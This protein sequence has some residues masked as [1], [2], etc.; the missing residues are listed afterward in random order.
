MSGPKTVV[1]G[2]DP[3]VVLL[4]AAGIRATRAVMQAQER[5]A[6]LEQA[7]GSERDERRDRLISAHRDASASLEAAAA[8]AEE[9]LQRLI[10]VCGASPNVQHIQASRPIRPQG[11]THAELAAYV[12]GLSGFGDELEAILRTE[13]ARLKDEPDVALP[14][15]VQAAGQPRE[16]LVERLLGRIAHLGPPPPDITALA[17]EL[18]GTPPGERAL[19]LASELRRR[20]QAYAEEDY[21][22]RTE[23]ATATIVEQ[24]LRD[25]GY[26]VED[27]PNTLFLEGGVAHFRRRDWGDYMVRM[28]V[29]STE[30]AANF[31]VVR[32]ERPGAD[33]T[34]IMDHL[35]EDRWCA[36][37]PVLLKT[38]EARGAL[39]H[40][41]RKLAP[42]ELPVQR[43]DPAQLPSFADDEEEASATPRALRQ[44]R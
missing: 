2:A 33:A 5:A 43:V 44:I 22:R 38:L 31:N 10:E 37:F 19:L 3:F 9:R 41:T 40:V 21:H 28:R 27:I 16:S 25:L 42:G 1:I 18:D 11:A 6:V 35:A 20:V 7:H 4:A 39:V 17:R 14:D 13:A 30:G 15:A 32:A 34:S 8:A 36:E 29:D 24:S 23:E 12:R 26:Q